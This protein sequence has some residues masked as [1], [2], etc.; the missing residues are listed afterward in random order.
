ME[1]KNQQQKEPKEQLQ[2][3]QLKAQKNF[4]KA[5]GS[6]NIV[7]A[8]RYIKHGAR[9]NELVEAELFPLH[10][11]NGNLLQVGRNIRL[12]VK[13]NQLVDKDLYPLHIATSCGHMRMVKLLI[14]CGA[15]VNAVAVKSG[16]TA[17][18]IAAESGFLDIIEI[19]L[20]AKKPACLNI[21]TANHVGQTAVYLAAQNGHT[22]V[23]TNLVK[24]GVSVTATAVDGSCPLFAAVA[25]Q[26]LSAVQE[27]MNL[28]AQINA[29]GERDGFTALF[30]AAA[31]GRADMVSMLKDFGADLNVQESRGATA[32]FVAAQN[33]C[34]EVLRKLYSLGANV[35]IPANDGVTAVCIAAD[36]GHTE[37]VIALAG[38]G[39]DLNKAGEADGYTPLCVAAQKGHLGVL[40]ALLDL[41]AD[42]NIAAKDMATP[43]YIA[44]QNG[45]ADAVRLLAKR[46]VNVNQPGCNGGPPVLIAGIKGHVA[47]I[48]LLYKLGADMTAIQEHPA[49]A[50]E[51]AIACIVKILEKMTR[52]CEH[53]GCQS[54]R[55]DRP[56]SLCG[57][58]KKV[59]YCSRECQVKDY[60][61]HKTECK[62][63]APVTVPAITS[64]EV[65]PSPVSV[66][67]YDP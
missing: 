35:N 61:K 57:R 50:A 52:E 11:A 13:V 27:L 20:E 15:N 25:G 42:P 54:S 43:M 59:H 53:C 37:A 19:L 29:P 66:I 17:L 48:K 10:L 21:H 30:R 26:H 39:A 58:C 1:K 3:E 7:D 41:G 44:A 38:M 4:Y 67:D 49:Y 33:G 31:I 2:K 46:G 22:H 12:G 34:V 16:D 24:L 56:M 63:A 60:K 36:K 32:M 45:Y 28:G 40:E 62:A 8:H 6:D 23:I 64:A 47:V 9:V 5:L 18:G 51:S 14:E 65:I 55:P